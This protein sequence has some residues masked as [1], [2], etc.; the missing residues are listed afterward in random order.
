MTVV[1]LKSICE[2]ASV[3]LFQGPDEMVLLDYRGYSV[4]VNPTRIFD[5]FLNEIHE[6]KFLIDQ[7][8]NQTTIVW[9]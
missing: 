2:P 4:Q 8:K 3:S 6:Q 1:F 5:S 9:C 7:M